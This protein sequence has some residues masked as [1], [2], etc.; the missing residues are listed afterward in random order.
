[1]S[2]RSH[3]STFAVPDLQHKVLSA[4]S[5]AGWPSNHPFQRKSADPIDDRKN[6][7]FRFHLYLLKCLASDYSVRLNCP[8][9]PETREHERVTARGNMG[10][11]GAAMQAALSAAARGAVPGRRGRRARPR[12]GRTKSQSAPGRQRTQAFSLFDAGVKL[13]KERHRH[14]TAGNPPIAENL[15]GR[16]IP[17]RR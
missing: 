14:S 8:A 6:L 9:Q 13:K 2:A 4:R 12:R 5:A 7:K 1:M 11:R 3:G 16:P 17:V 15:Y 10:F